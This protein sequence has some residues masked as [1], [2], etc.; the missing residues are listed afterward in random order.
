ML[1]KSVI[2]LTRNSVIALTLLFVSSQVSAAVV[3]V[4]D[5]TFGPGSV[6]RDLDHGRDFLNIG[7]TAGMT[8]D[9]VVPLLGTAFAGW[10]I[11]TVA[12]LD[13]LRDSMG[14]INWSDDPAQV[15]IV[16]TVIAMFC[17]VPANCRADTSIARRV[18]GSVQ[19]LFVI[20]PGVTSNMAYDISVLFTGITSNLETVRWEQQGYSFT[21]VNQGVFLTRASVPEPTTLGMLA[22]GFLGLGIS[23]RK[24]A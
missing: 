8:I 6:V 7:A 15:A 4:N 24:K 5:A 3:L 19:E 11:S 10:E 12:F 1:Q 16:D 23:R 17:A 22:L 21:N 18:R 14:V 13:D 20:S 9:D 2:A